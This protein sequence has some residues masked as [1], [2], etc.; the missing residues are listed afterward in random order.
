MA[1]GC[2]RCDGGGTCIQAPCNMDCKDWGEWCETIIRADFEVAPEL[3]TEEQKEKLALFN[4]CYRIERCSE[5]MKRAGLKEGECV[6]HINN[7]FPQSLKDFADLV[8]RLDAGD[9]LKI[10]RDGKRVDVT[11]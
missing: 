6:S 11:L 9:E 5:L 4:P 10:W 1:G 3:A 7:I 2:E 8:E